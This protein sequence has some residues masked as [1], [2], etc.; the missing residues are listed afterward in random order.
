M[1]QKKSL[2]ILIAGEDEDLDASA[3]AWDPGDPLTW[4][5]SQPEA[6]IAHMEL[7]M[8]A[9]GGIIGLK[10]IMLHNKIAGLEVVVMV[11]SKSNHCFVNEITIGH[12]V[13]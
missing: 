10:T 3:N 2:R 12:L 9:L 11:D 4:L 13:L 5:P 6:H 7:S 8:F 1:C